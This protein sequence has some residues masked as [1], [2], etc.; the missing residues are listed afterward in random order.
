MEVSE[1]ARW[2]MA[3][4]EETIELTS[5]VWDFL[6]APAR[7]L[8]VGRVGRQLQHL[9]ANRKRFLQRLVEGH[10]ETEKGEE[11]TRRRVVGVLLELQK[12]DSEACTD[13]LI[14]SLCI[15]S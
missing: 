1:E 9:Q 3:T 4:A 8:D 2:F 12:E 10:R 11:V 14:H 6:P 15:V 5:T 7:W 13:Q